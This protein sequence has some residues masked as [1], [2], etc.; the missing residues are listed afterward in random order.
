M[1][2]AA[3]TPV[4]FSDQPHEWAVVEI[5]KWTGFASGLNPLAERRNGIGLPGDPSKIFCSLAQHRHQGTVSGVGHIVK[6]AAGGTGN[7]PVHL[8]QVDPT[9]CCRVCYR[10]NWR[11]FL[12][13]WMSFH[14]AVNVRE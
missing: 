4:P 5:G 8:T 14:V 10:R 11:L 1:Q 7:L 2:Q 12:V 3:D 9:R 13:R 6:S